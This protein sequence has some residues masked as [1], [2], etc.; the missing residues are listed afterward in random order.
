MMELTVSWGRSDVKWNYSDFV[1]EVRSL[2][3][4]LDA[5]DFQHGPCGVYC[6]HLGS[7]VAICYGGE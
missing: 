4:I 1:E 7:R 6:L 5:D 2:W 3:W